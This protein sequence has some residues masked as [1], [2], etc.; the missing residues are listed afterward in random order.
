MEFRKTKIE[1]IL[2]VLTI[3]NQA[4]SY[5]KEK[6]IDQW[7]SGYP[8]RQS[9]EED[10]LKSHSYVL[11]LNNR[12]VGTSAISFEG[13]KTY[14]K[15]YKGEWLTHESYG[16]IHRIAVDSNLKGQGLASIILKNV[17][18][19]SIDKDI[20]SIKMDTHKDNLSMQKLLKK[21]DFKY[22]GIIFLE[23]GNERVAFE[24]NF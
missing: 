24:K 9:I 7:Q 14:N 5:F 23:D 3:I 16:V 2:N 10:I 11:I 19:L 22:C 4:K 1:D 8:N 17:E 18:K 15:I 21:N 6:E 13:E 12:I 20:H